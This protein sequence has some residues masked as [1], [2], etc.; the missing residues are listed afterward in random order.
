MHL[1]VAPYPTPVNVQQTRIVSVTT[2]EAD[3]SHNARKGYDCSIDAMIGPYSR[4]G[5][6]VELI[7]GTRYYIN[8]ANAVDNA[9][10]P[11]MRLQV[12]FTR[13]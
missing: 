5:V 6:Y 12:S 4:A 9:D 7:A 10:G 1:S 11:E 2:T 13:K 8:V 3:F